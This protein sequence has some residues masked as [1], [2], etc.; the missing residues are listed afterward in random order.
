M[1]AARPALIVLDVMMPDLDG[2]E[3]CRRLRQDGDRTPVV[4]L[5]AKDGA[6]D[7]VRG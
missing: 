2:F 3:V 1:R 4:F 5:T 7:A 6:E